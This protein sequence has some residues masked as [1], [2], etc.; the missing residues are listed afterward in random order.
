MS[1]QIPV[2]GSLAALPLEGV[3]DF[4]AERARLTKEIAKQDGETAKIAAKL[5]NE[6]FVRRAKPEVV[7]EQRERLA[8][9]ESRRA[10]L[11]LALSR[12]AH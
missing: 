12:L 2:R 4:A 5:G 7:E 1:V 10:K 3:I 9:V 11:Q 8:E 6:D